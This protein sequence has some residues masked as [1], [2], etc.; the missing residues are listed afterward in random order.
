MKN[1]HPFHANAILVSSHF[2]S[3]HFSGPAMNTVT[4]PANPK[5]WK[6]E[7]M[8]EVNHSRVAVS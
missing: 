4:V 7:G 8:W 1:M 6:V 5:K 3:A 2:C